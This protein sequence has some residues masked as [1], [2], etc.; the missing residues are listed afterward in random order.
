MEYFPIS[1]RYLMVQTYLGSFVL[2]EVGVREVVLVSPLAR[3]SVAVI[4][5]FSLKSNLEF[6]WDK[7]GGEL[8]HFV[9]KQLCKSSSALIGSMEEF[10]VALYYK[11]S[12]TLFIACL[13]NFKKQNLEA[14][15]IKE[16][17]PETLLKVQYPQLCLKKPFFCLLLHCI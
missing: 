15:A 16:L 5:F 17:L 2:R 4:Q 3:V 9:E 1:L 8:W 6:P 10:A 14:E 7:Q 11:H 13:S 12:W